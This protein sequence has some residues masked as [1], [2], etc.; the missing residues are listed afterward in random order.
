MKKITGIH[1]TLFN[2][3][4][5]QISV[6]RHD[7]D[8]CAYNALSSTGIEETPYRF[9]FNHE[10]EAETVRQILSILGYEFVVEKVDGSVMRDKLTES[11]GAVEIKEG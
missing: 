4:F 3:L 6:F 7:L 11:F 9:I 10:D 5:S 8:E 2:G 1:S